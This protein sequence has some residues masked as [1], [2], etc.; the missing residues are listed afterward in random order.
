M[1]MKLWLATESRRRWHELVHLWINNDR[2][3][4]FTWAVGVLGFLEGSVPR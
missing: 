1:P 2:F 4:V 3:M